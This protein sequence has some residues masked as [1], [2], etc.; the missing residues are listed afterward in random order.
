MYNG[1]DVANA[2]KLD[3]WQGVAQWNSVKDEG[4]KLTTQTSA[5]VLL[6]NAGRADKQVIPR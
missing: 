2:G 1:Y 4:S 6:F 5:R 3:I